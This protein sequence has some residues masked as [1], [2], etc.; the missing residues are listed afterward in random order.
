MG[1][2]LSNH[3]QPCDPAA[4]DAALLA[5]GKALYLAN[6]FESKCRYVLRIAN[7]VSFLD[8]HPGAGLDDAIASLAR[9]KF[10]HPT[11]EGLKTFP[12]VKENEVELLDKARDAR[13]FIAHEGG[14]FGDIFYAREPHIREHLDRLR[15]AVIDL[16][17][18]DNIVS[19]WVYEIDEKEPA[20]LGMML[21]YPAL[22]EQWVFGDV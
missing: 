18:G 1:W 10:L 3:L 15:K 19:R 16:A 5:A 14:A 17:G 13:N 11:I 7:L 2:S 20:P 6:A 12:I 4:V 8:A 21:S 22:V 9:D